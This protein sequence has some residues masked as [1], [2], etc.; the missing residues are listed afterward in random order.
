MRRVTLTILL[1][2]ACTQLWAQEKNFNVG[3]TMGIYDRYQYGHS[4]IIDIHKASSYNDISYVSNP[5]VLPTISVE[6]GYIFPG[7]HVGAFVGT[8]WSYAWNNLNGGP[9]PL[10]ED[11]CIVHI[12]PQVR[13]YYLYTGDIRLYAT[14]G[15]G[16]RVRTFSE[17]FE[18]DTIRAYHAEFSY[19]LSPFGMSFGG[20]WAFSCDF[21]HGTAWSMFNM[22]ASYRF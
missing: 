18:G 1:A 15:A 13:L 2:V 22:T 20:R 9:S 5:H 16:V 7:N 3:F 19:V 10:R 11:E 14:L 17:T 21:G 6:G 4:E 12:I 8:Y